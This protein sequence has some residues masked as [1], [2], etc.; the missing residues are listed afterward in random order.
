MHAQAAAAAAILVEAS[1]ECGDTDE[2]PFSATEL[3]SF[4]VHHPGS[5]SFHESAISRRGAI[6][7]TIVSTSEDREGREGPYSSI[8]TFTLHYSKAVKALPLTDSRLAD[9]SIN[10]GLS[11]DDEHYRGEATL[12]DDLTDSSEAELHELDDEE[13][14]TYF[15]ERDGKLFHNTPESPYP[16]PVDANELARLDLMHDTLYRLLGAHYL[17][18]VPQ[19]LASTQDGRKRKALD[20]CTGNGKWVMDMAE[21]FPEVKFR[22]VDIL[23]IST[24]Y[25]LPNVRFEMHDVGQQSRWRDGAF[26]LIHARDISM[27]IRN[28]PNLINECARLLRPGGLFVSCEWIHFPVA[29]PSADHDANTYAPASVRFFNTIHQILQREGVQLD[30]LN[31]HLSLTQSPQFT[32]IS[33]ERRSAPIGQW[34]ED[35]TWK[36]IGNDQKIIFQRFTGSVMPML[37]NAGMTEAAAGQLTADYLEEV[38]NKDGLV[39]EYVITHARKV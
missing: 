23:P 38:D 39:C 9:A 12:E 18:P 6:S 5:N 15:I 14:V 33:T 35:E 11:L 1:A 25:P 24:R 27:A 19:V 21:A 16:L 20:I 34:P 37:T 2:T 28:W 26:D 30:P 3:P 13:I 8:T 29:D 36:N 17:G 31:A 10:S 4:L 7:S 32:D 22:G